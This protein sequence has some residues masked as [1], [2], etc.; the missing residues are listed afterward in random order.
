MNYKD[1]NSEVLKS[2]FNRVFF[3]QFEDSNSTSPDSFELILTPEC[4]HKCKYCYIYK[5]KD[6]L[7]P[8][9][10]RDEKTILNN[11]NIFLDWYIE[12]KF[13]ASL[14]IFSGEVFSQKVGLD[15]L[16]LIFEKFKNIPIEESSIK[17]IIIPTNMS[18]LS[19]EKL[20]QEV[21]KIIDDFKSIGITI[22]LSASVDGKYLEKNREVASSEFERNDKFYDNLFDFIKEY[23]VGVHP[24][25]SS[26]NIENWIDNYKWF[27][28]RLNNEQYSIYMR[29]PMMLEVRDDNW[30][31]ESISHYL[32][33]LNSIIDF[34]YDLYVK[35]NKESEFI[36][37]ILGGK[38][39][40]NYDNIAITVKTD[41]PND[42][43]SCG[44]QNRV[45]VRIGDLSL[46]PCHRTMYPQYIYGKFSI[47]DN[48]IVDIEGE[49]VALATTIYSM[50][51]NNQ[52]VCENCSIKYL[53]PKGCLGSQLEYSNNL[54]HP[55]EM[56]CN[57]YKAKFSFLLLKYKEMGLIDKMMEMDS[58][59]QT[60]KDVVV[61]I[62]NK[63][64]GK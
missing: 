3:K 11:L 27:I 14:E 60:I 43:L 54:F 38:H 16:N 19:I 25:V 20:T 13:H 56:V 62:Y 40:N 6:E 42:K 52:P 41:G 22:F 35:N 8:E 64:G 55:N 58:I 21:K 30:T 1:S 51:S 10:I 45:C 50:K 37:R 4:N 23:N 47:E 39:V 59:S 28:D 15:A 24:M 18:F 48:K 9:N 32:K 2:L 46:V 36:K 33:F 31:N 34:E 12:N 63:V 49:N 57:L 5:H 17:N 53:C 7:Y 26:F 61:N 29:R 44:I